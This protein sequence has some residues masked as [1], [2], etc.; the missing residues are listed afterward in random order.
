MTTHTTAPVRFPK[1]WF[2]LTIVYSF[3]G[4]AILASIIFSLL[5]FLSI[6]NNPLMKWLFGA[7]A[8]IFELGKFYVW[9]EFGER[10][11]RRDISGALSALVFYSILAAISIGGSI[12]GINSAT[13]TALNIQAQ[14]QRETARYDE[15]IAAIERQIKLNETAAMKYIELDRISSGVKRM[16]EA[17]TALRLQQDKLRLERDARPVSEQ[18]SMLGLMSSLADGLHWSVAQ[19]QFALV[20]F[21]SLL[22]DVFAAFFVGLIGE[23]NRFRRRWMAEQQEKARQA[24]G[25]AAIAA[26]SEAMA[27][28]LPAEPPLTPF[29][30]VRNAL[31]NGQL[32]CS[33]KQVAQELQLPPEHVDNIFHQ[34]MEQGILGQR[35]NRHYYVNSAIE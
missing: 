33:K 34:L 11:A 32:R 16:Q 27:S 24:E 14:H 7:L 28:E 17:N 1:E 4:A 2:A 12:G 9:Y 25:E 15:Q 29:E 13:N 23:E 21:L 6:D 30:R 20:C 26:E 35:P 19:V 5:L 22:L 10:R 18:S 31:L 3:T 8:V